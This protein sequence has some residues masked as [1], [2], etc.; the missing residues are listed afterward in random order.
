MNYRP[1]VIGQQDPAPAETFTIDDL[2]K[3]VHK[4]TPSLLILGIATGAAFAIGSGLAHR[5]FF[6]N[7][8]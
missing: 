5:Y 6:N 3:A 2:A 1:L 8:K 4:V 7:K